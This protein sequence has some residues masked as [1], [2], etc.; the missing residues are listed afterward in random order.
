MATEIQG[1]SLVCLRSEASG[2]TVNVLT[3]IFYFRAGFYVAHAV[4]E[5]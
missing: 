2:A 3:S 4:P 1:V 5:L